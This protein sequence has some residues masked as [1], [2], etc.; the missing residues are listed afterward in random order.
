MI[1]NIIKDYGLLIVVTETAIII[2]LLLWHFLFSDDK[3]YVI[4]DLEHDNNRLKKQLEATLKQLSDYENA[5]SKIKQWENWYQQNKHLIVRQEQKSKTIES[6]L[7]RENKRQ[8]SASKVLS[9]YLQV[10]V[11]GKFMNLLSS[12][13][14]CFFRT[15][16]EYGVRKYEFCGNV[17]KALANLNA[18]F[19]DVC[20][21]E[22]KRNGA[23]DITNECAGTLDSELRI[24]RKAKIRLR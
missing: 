18:I 22:G 4:V 20:E 1:E 13:E 10:A 23:T 14:K 12:P 17:A 6:D 15:W 16:E 2:A 5:K 8:T 19:D 24:T 9:Q 11:G 7:S 3:S 21:I